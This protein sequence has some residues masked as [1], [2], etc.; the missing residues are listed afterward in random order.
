MISCISSQVFTHQ[1][2]HV[3]N[4]LMVERGRT[5]SRADMGEGLEEA[6]GMRM[7][8]KG[9]AV[10]LDRRHLSQAK[11]GGGWGSAHLELRSSPRVA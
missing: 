7:A 4:C 10:P 1:V 9:E 3:V 11:R 8:L 5:L 6:R 2:L